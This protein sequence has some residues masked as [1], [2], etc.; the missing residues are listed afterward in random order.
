[1]SKNRDV[2]EMEFIYGQE[3][4]TVIQW[5]LR[6]IV[7]F[8]FLLFS[9]KIMGQRSI[10]QLRLLD[11]VMALIIGNIMAHPLSDERLGLAG[12]M[13][14]MTVLI[15]LYIMCVFLSLKWPLFRNF[16]DHQ[17]YPLI[18]NSQILYK[19]LAKAR[20]SLD[21]LLSELRKQQ[22]SDIQ[23][24]ALAIWEPDGNISILLNSQ[25]QSVTKLDMQIPSNPFSL[26]RTVI[27]EGKLDFNEL[28][29]MGKDEVWLKGKLKETYKGELNHILLATIDQSEK[30]NIFLYR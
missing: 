5:V 14:T 27:K 20:I 8:F 21:V 28:N 15:L 10:S 6:A 30:L 18:K 26:P 25:Y 29:E 23:H 3:S 7:A 2:N 1:M 11:F 12:S 24:V 19:N 9:A 22:I 17:P 13:T 16:L 4:L